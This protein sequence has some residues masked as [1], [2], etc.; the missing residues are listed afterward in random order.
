[1]LAVDWPSNANRDYSQLEAE[2]GVP[3]TSVLLR[4]FDL[5]VSPWSTGQS[6]RA[7]DDVAQLLVSDRIAISDE[8]CCALSVFVCLVVNFFSFFD[9]NYY[10][11]AFIRMV[12]FYTVKSYDHLQCIC[13]IN[14]MT[15]N[16]CSIYSC[17]LNGHILSIL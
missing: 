6:L 9:K 16:Q 3:S 12:I 10:S 5:D 4:E 17:H 14:R 13:I 7:S 11:V 2:P 8:S 1:M 15:R